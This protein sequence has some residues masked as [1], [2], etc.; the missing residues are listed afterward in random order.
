MVG[1]IEYV[2][3]TDLYQPAAT[4]LDSLSQIAGSHAVQQVAQLY[5]ALGLVHSGIG[6]TVDDTVYLVLV[7]E[8]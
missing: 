6:S 2:V 3:S 7:H 8:L 1:A 5:V 4:P